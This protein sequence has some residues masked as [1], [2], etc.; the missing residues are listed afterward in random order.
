MS[1]QK[2]DPL[3]YI[4]DV[5]DSIERIEAYSSGLKLED[6][7]KNNLVI[8]AIVRNFE[9]IGEAV[10]HIPKIFRARTASTLAYHDMSL[11]RF[12]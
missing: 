9:I 12:A 1:K 4:H 2:R 7:T 10:K 11:A 6:F 3:L 5:L 8:D